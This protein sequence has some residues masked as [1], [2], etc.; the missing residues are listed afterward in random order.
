MASCFLVLPR[1]DKEVDYARGFA[2]LARGDFRITAAVYPLSWPAIAGLFFCCGSVGKRDRI[3]I[4]DEA[5]ASTSS[6][7]YK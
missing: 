6:N 3:E 2:A 1:L 7:F 4:T 5:N